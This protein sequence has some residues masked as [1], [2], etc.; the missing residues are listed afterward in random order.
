MRNV[1]F[2]ERERLQRNLQKSL[3]N[4]QSLFKFTIDLHNQVN[5]SLGKKFTHM[6]RLFKYIT[7]NPEKFLAEQPT[8]SKKW[9]NLKYL[10]ISAAI[11]CISNNNGCLKN[12]L[13]IT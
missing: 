9:F 7:H 5:Q 3:D 12:I 13:K 10:G 1:V 2:T 6:M 8:F 4:K 11:W